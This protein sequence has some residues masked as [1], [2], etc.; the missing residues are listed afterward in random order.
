M[1][2]WVLIKKSTVILVVPCF[3]W[4]GKIERI[5]E[6]LSSQDRCESIRSVGAST[7]ITKMSGRMLLLPTIDHDSCVWVYITF[8]ETT[9]ARGNG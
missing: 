1:K 9:G 8:G 3:D 4:D 6:D 7:M 5:S 2:V